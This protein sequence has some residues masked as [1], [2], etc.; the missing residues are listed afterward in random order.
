MLM[1]PKTAKIEPG[2]RDFLCLEPPSTDDA[3]S[4]AADIAVSYFTHPALGIL[5]ILQATSKLSLKPALFLVFPLPDHRSLAIHKLLRS[6]L[7][8][9]IKALVVTLNP[10]NTSNTLTTTLTTT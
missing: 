9:P 1:P 2:R 7:K 10:I 3:E 8:N 5:Q 6:S 4:F